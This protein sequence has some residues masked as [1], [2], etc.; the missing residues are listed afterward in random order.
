MNYLLKNAKQAT[1]A[2]SVG[3]NKPV[4]GSGGVGNDAV[5]RAAA[6]DA[7]TNVDAITAQPGESI[8]PDGIVVTSD[9]IFKNKTAGA[10]TLDGTDPQTGA[11]VQAA[12]LEP[13][14][15]E[16]TLTGTNFTLTTAAFANNEAPTIAEVETY[17]VNTVGAASSGD[18]IYFYTSPDG[19][20]FTWANDDANN[21]QLV[22]TYDPNQGG[23]SIYTP[24]AA[25]T[26][27]G[28]DTDPKTL[29][30]YGLDAEAPITQPDA[31]APT[32]DLVSYPLPAPTAA[33]LRFQARRN[34][35]A[36]PY[37]DGIVDG[38]TGFRI[39]AIG[40]TIDFVSADNGAGGFHWL[41]GD[42]VSI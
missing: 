34:S 14:T 23:G 29:V 16:P 4:S 7:K 20:K 38:Q 31:D 21:I 32:D 42:T 39:N 8:P 26:P 11:S 17:R 19:V 2:G 3:L 27:L 5:A 10:L 35:A 18:D 1:L 28:A 24:L 30:T 40:V 33:G 15:S 12:G 9:G 36:E 22:S 6:S 41:Y 37:L 25:V 13:F